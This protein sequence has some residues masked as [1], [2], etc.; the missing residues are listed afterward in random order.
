MNYYQNT[1]LMINRVT[2]KVINDLGNELSGAEKKRVKR[3]FK[4][5]LWQ[6]SLW[7]HYFRYKDWF[8]VLV[9]TG[10]FNRL[11]NWGISQVARARYDTGEPL[12]KNFFDSKGYCRLSSTVYYGAMIYYYNYIEA[13]KNSCNGKDTVDQLT[14]A[15]N[16]YSSGQSTCYKDLS[17]ERK[18]IRNFQIFAMKG[19]RQN[20]KNRPWRLKLRKTEG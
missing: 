8:F 11:G 15:Y 6:E 20:Y 12:A 18:D 9:S 1:S 19:F 2:E 13:R 4:A 5:V 16:A 7:R 17:A 10:G 3:A 14:G